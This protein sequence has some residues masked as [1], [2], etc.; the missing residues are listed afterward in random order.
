MPT[1]YMKNGEGT[2]VRPRRGR[3]SRIA[4][5]KSVD[6]LKNKKRKQSV[7]DKVKKKVGDVWDEG[8]QVVDDGVRLV[9]YG[10]QYAKNHPA[11]AA[12]A[13]GAVGVLG[14]TAGA[15]AADLYVHRATL[16]QKGLKGELDA[17]KKAYKGDWKGLAKQTLGTTSAQFAEDL[18]GARKEI[19]KFSNFNKKM[20]DGSIY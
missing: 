9:E 1:I 5:N 4:V 6:K 14:P 10:A 11:K 19:E 8:R 17:Y 12:A 3:P 13:L 2:A 20:Q 18:H 7:W 16:K 15:A